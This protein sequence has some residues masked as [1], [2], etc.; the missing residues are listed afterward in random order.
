MMKTLSKK[1]KII[2]AARRM[3]AE[4]GYDGTSIRRIAAAAGVSLPLLVHH[5]KSKEGLFTEVYRTAAG[6]SLKRREERMAEMLATAGNI[7]VE[8]ILQA[9]SNSWL[10]LWAEDKH[11]A[12]LMIQF[13]E[14]RPFH[15]ELVKELMDPTSMMFLTA[16]QELSPNVD[17]HI[18]HSYFHLY[19]GGLTHFYLNHERIERLSGPETANTRET[20]AEFSVMIGERLRALSTSAEQ[21]PSAVSA[22]A[23]SAG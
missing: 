8:N 4:Q 1:E 11:T 6:V 9:Y 15:Q 14:G 16:L 5:F 22:G 17:P 23:G 3:F 2:D 20:L 10:D 13:L 21:L 7:S 18:I 19:A 12:L